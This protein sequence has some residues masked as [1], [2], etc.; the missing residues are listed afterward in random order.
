MFKLSFPC[1]K[2]WHRKKVFSFSLFLYGF[3][4]TDCSS[5]AHCVWYWLYQQLPCA[6]VCS[7]VWSNERR[8]KVAG[9]S[10]CNSDH[11]PHSLNQIQFIYSNIIHK[12]L[13]GWRKPVMKQ[14]REN[15]LKESKWE[16]KMNIWKKTT[17]VTSRW[18]L[19]VEEHESIRQKF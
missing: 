18:F 13:D 5:L 8:F 19:Y 12:E 3:G 11:V 10:V 4:S 15:R 2:T 1:K 9:R 7:S 17:I 6:P 14:L 16:E